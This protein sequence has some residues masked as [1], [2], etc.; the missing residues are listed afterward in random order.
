ME[1]RGWLSSEWSVTDT[2][3]RARFYKLTRA[4]RAQLAAELK[5]WSRLTLAVNDVM[6][7]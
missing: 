5:S 7:S 6:G 2:G 4:G 3:R 1:S